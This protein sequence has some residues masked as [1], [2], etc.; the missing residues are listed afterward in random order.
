MLTKEKYIH[1]TA[2]VE[3]NVEI[4]DGTKI[5]HYAHIREHAQIGKNCVIGKDVYIDHDVKIGNG[6]KI[7]NGV[8]VFNGVTLEDDVLIGPNVTFTNDRY[9]RAFP[10]T[11]KIVP[12]LIRKGVGVG[13]GTVIVCGVE[14]GE[15]ALI[16]AGSIVT[17]DILPYTLA[18]GNPAKFVS[19]VCRCGQSRV[20]SQGELCSNC[21]I[22]GFSDLDK[23]MLREGY[24]RND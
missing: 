9:P 17:S 8:S 12:T 1:H 20:E 3:D 19:W 15:Y 22:E 4:G 21:K 10:H 14:I 2:T 5:W 24:V 13:A 16:G 23:T 11:W 18:Y 7:E 6:C